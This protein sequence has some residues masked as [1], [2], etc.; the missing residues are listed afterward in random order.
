MLSS[1]LCIGANMT[2]TSLQAHLQRT[3]E[4]NAIWAAH[5][6]CVNSLE[7]QAHLAF[8]YGLVGF[9]KFKDEDQAFA[10]VNEGGMVTKDECWAVSEEGWP[11]RTVTMLTVID[12]QVSQPLVRKP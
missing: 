5:E 11:R 2:E 10:W 8:S 6:A 1:I 9:F 4:R 12:P 3:M 7:N